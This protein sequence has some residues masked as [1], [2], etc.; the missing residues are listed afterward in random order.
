M[1][2][3]RSSKKTS[4]P[5]VH[6]RDVWSAGSTYNLVLPANNCHEYS[7]RFVKQL[8]DFQFHIVKHYNSK[9]EHILAALQFTS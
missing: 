3:F 4:F 6:T 7:Y 2:N 5:T 1:Y 8:V 9:S